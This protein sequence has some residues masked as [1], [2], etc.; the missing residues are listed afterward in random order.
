MNN[1]SAVRAP[2]SAYLHIPFCHRRCFYCD[3]SVVPL[4]DR[5]GGGVGPGSSS[6]KDYLILLHK[7]ISICPLGPPLSTVYI[8]GGTP[9]I[10]TPEQVSSLLEHLQ[11]HFGIQMGAEITLEMDPASFDE[12]L[13]RNFLEAGISRV[14]LGCQ[15]FNNDFLERLGRRHKRLDAINACKW[16]NSFQ[17]KGILESWSIDLIQNLPW[18]DLEGWKKEL[19]QA[20]ETEA[21]HL[22]IYDL[23]IE[24]GTVFEKRS[25]RGE[26]ELLDHDLAADSMELTSVM[27]REAGISRYEVSNYAKPGHASRHNRV[28]W[29]GGGWW[30]FGQGATS[31]PWGRR[32]ARPRTRAL[33]KDWLINQEKQ[34]VDSSLLSLNATTF[35][36]DEK[37]LVGL[38]CREGV[39]IEQAFKNWGWDKAQR[40]KN[41]S[42]FYSKLKT[43]FEK[44]WLLKIGNRIKLSEPDGMAISNQILVEILLWWDSLPVDAVVEPRLEGNQ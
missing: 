11:E 44:G 40:K 18:Q 32:F 17:G 15:S 10:L 20:I 4:G 30:A 21:P 3:F 36:L 33:Y 22:S 28:Y 39:D 29:H 26:L 43:A 27:L 7:E 41:L 38:R 31:S 16:L 12:D 23:S 19:S 35:P 25:R 5:A 37:L 2:R 1:A 13:L 9:S 42:T 14:S 8:G 24:P 6:I 34:G